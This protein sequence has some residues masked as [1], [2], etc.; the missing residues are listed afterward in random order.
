MAR[1]MKAAVAHAFREPLT[2][3]VQR[4]PNARWTSLVTLDA[5]AR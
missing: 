1:M 4:A 3:E 5:I 2:I